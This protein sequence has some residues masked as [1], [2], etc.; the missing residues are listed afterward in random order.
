M[1]YNFVTLNKDEAAFF[2]E[3]TAVPEAR[4]LLKVVLLKMFIPPCYF[5]M[6]D[7]PHATFFYV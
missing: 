2:V 7:F 5:P 1:T 3:I 6:L 4:L